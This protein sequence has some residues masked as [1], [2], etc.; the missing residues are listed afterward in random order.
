MRSNAYQQMVRDFMV[1]ADTLNRRAAYDYVR[2]GGH[3]GAPEQPTRHLPIDVYAT[4][5]AFVVNAYLPGVSP[6]NVEI[7]FEEE[8]LTIR[9]GFAPL[10]EE[11]RLIR[12]EL[13]HGRFERRVTF[14]V[15]VDADNIAADYNNG[16]LTLRMPKAEAIKPKQ[17]KVQ[18]R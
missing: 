3:A 9:G 13:F 16:L 2:N 17:I 1:M 5:E 6:E 4:D 11:A 8:A 14:Q 15:P 18:V 12:G 7:V 10:P